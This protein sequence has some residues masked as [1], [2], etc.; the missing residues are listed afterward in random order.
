MSHIRATFDEIDWSDSAPGLRVK[1]VIN[2]NKQLRLVEFTEAYDKEA[3]CSI[4]HTGLVME[5]RLTFSFDDSEMNLVAGQAFQIS[6]GEQ[7]RHRTI[8][9]PGDYAVLFLTEDIR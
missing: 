9:Q 5:G 8:I 1:Q 7:D 2:G 6:D 4:G 3:W